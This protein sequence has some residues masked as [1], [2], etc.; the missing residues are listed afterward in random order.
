MSQRLQ[1][2]REVASI[3]PFDDEET[4]AWHDTLAWIDSGVEICRIQKPATPP[5][6]LV[7]YFVIMDGDHILL[8]DHIISG[9]LLPPGGHV[10]PG[11]H[12]R[13]TVERE[14]LEELGLRADFARSGPQ[15]LTSAVTVGKTPGHT[16]I[17]LWYLLNGDKTRSLDFDRQEYTMIHWLHRDEIPVERTDPNLPRFLKKLA[18]TDCS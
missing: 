6:H 5:K 3:C 1:I 7:S 17:T 18:Q 10:E 8:G 12:P 2:R 15:F 9:R 13:T 4:S 14:C 11:E 16:D